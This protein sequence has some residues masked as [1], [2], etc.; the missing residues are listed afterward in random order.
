MRET[1]IEAL[2]KE[3]RT[4][5]R[6]PGAK[7]RAL[8]IGP[9]LNEKA[10]RPGVKSLS[11]DGRRRS[12]EARL[13]EAHGLAGAIDLDIIASKLVTLANIRPATFLGK[14]KV[15]EI[16]D[17]IRAEEIDLV[18]M[19]CA[20]SPV[21]QRNLEKAFS[22]KV[23]DR[24]GLILEIFGRR[25]RTREGALQV[26]LAHLAY[27]KS[28]LVRSWTHLERQR[29]GFGFLGGP[30]ETQIETDRR[31]IQERMTKIE[32]ELEGVKRTRGL[33]RKSRTAVPYPI[34]AL[35]GYTNA[36]KSTLF[37]RLTKAE[38]LA[39]DMLFATLDPTLRAVVLEHGGEII[40]S[41]T[42]GFISDLPTMLVSAFRATLEEVLEAD[43]I[44]HVRDI[45][46]E[47]AEAQLGDVEAIL[48]DLGVDPNDHRRLLEV[49][50]KADLLDEDSLAAARGSAKRRRAQS[51]DNGR[52]VIVSALTGQGLDELREEIES[53]L[54][55]GR[56]VL[57]IVLKPDNGEGLHWL[58]ENAEVMRKSVAADGAVHVRVR[59]APERAAAL[60][61]KF[62]EPAAA[63]A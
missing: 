1:K 19:D 51:G 39:E 36:G 15:E 22:A 60:R 43:L 12:P 11:P 29:G 24:T 41:D 23:I 31:L 14:G 9:Y 2:A 28:R 30:G 10:V 20:L 42:V 25:A 44:L 16:A 7:T 46:H 21:Q 49:W 32:R 33:H 8:V 58:Y 18:I 3:P 57:E 59:V 53:R 55:V 50:N 40:L 45:A 63:S 34:V 17:L 26:E 38:V 4:A 27:Q 48:G 13:E 35:V 6:G 37:N 62:L 54:A 47:D 56:P 52:P 5:G 61:R